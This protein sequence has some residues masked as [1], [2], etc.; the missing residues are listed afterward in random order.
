V[1]WN[2]YDYDEQSLAG[3]TLPRRFQ[4]NLVSVALR[5]SF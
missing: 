3:P 4:A 2:Y 1:G 5:Y